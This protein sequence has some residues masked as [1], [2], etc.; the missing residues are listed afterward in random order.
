MVEKRSLAGGGGPDPKRPKTDMAEVIARARE[1]AAALKQKA[2]LKKSTPAATNGASISPA[3]ASSALRPPPAAPP[4]LDSGS[5]RLDAIRARV[6]AIQGKGSSTPPTELSKAAGKA[7]PDSDE[8]DESEEENPY[9]DPKTAGAGRAVRKFA[10]VQPGS[11][12]AQGSRKRDQDRLEDFKRSVARQ[13][14]MAGLDENAEKNFLAEAPPTVEFWDNPLFDPAVPIDERSYDTADVIEKCNMDEQ[15]DPINRF[16]QKPVIVKAP[17]DGL[18]VQ[19]KPLYLTKKEMAKTRRMRR[20]EDLKEKQ[21]KIRLGLEPPPVSSSLVV[22]CHLLTI[23]FQPPKVKR[24]NMM[25]VMGEQAI[26]DPTAVEQL[27]EAQIATRAA[28]HVKANEERKLTK[29]QRHAKLEQNQQ[30]DAAKGLRI[31]AVKINSLACG[32]HRYKVDHNAKEFAVTGVTM[33]SPK[34]CLILFEGG[35]H[36]TDK[37]KNVLLKRINWQENVAPSEA[38]RQKNA[39]DPE[40]LKGEDE[41]GQLKDLSKNKAVCI[42]EGDILERNYSRWGTRMMETDVDGKDFLARHRLES[43]WSIA[44]GT[45]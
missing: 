40:W 18:L 23:V 7:S 42:F 5:S 20:A 21:A 35:F 26:A 38:A 22:C 31:C 33:F 34:F 14:K 15:R 36:S 3:P 24:A 13:K 30:N 19:L 39:N 44:E 43:L 27:V 16:V 32:K 25:R 8:D 37:Y 4:V 12:I 45:A 28:E 11:F 9:W 10:F 1:K 29:E 2:D 17:Q 41:N 6:A